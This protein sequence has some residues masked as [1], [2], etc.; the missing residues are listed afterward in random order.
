[1]SEGIIIA[2]ITAM[3][4]LLGG[5]IGQIIVASATIRAAEIKANPNSASG[6]NSE[7]SRSLGGILRG[8]LIG[9][10]LTLGILAIFGRLKS[11]ITKSLNF[12]TC[13][14]RNAKANFY[15]FLP[16]CHTKSDT[17]ITDNPNPRCGTYE[18]ERIFFKRQK[19]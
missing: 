6:S 5:V 3:G 18:V 2:L 1:M 15:S 16:I 10:V 9:A 14:I 19:L 13:C 4:S 11:S 17:R 12:N 8:A 7:K